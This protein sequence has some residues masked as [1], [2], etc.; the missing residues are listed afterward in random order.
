MHKKDIQEGGY[1]IAIKNRLISLSVLFWILFALIY[2]LSL[3]DI[4]SIGDFIILDGEY[5]ISEQMSKYFVFLG[6]LISINLYSVSDRLDDIR[7]SIC[8]MVFCLVMYLAE[9]NM[10]TNTL[11]PLFG[12]ILLPYIFTILARNRSWIPFLSLVLACNLIMVGVLIDFVLD[13]QAGRAPD[14]ITTLLP[15]SVVDIASS[16]E[17]ETFE[18][19]GAAFICYSVAVYSINP[20]QRVFRKGKYVILGFL[21]ASAMIA[22]GNSFLHW[23]VAIGR[24]QTFAA[25]SLC[26]M[27]GVLL[28]VVIN[29]VNRPRIIVGMPSQRE[30]LTFIAYFFVVLPSIFGR[31]NDTLSLV[32]WFPLVVYIGML[33]FVNHPATDPGKCKYLYSILGK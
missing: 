18:P 21:I 25:V 24:V 20:L 8:F 31:V 33:L 9:S 4:E 11:Q 2:I 19:V 16:M 10:I 12:V 6:V 32:L 29:R 23:M 30:V 15:S 22:I 17:E 27:G 5:E 26:I 13:S 14:L 3:M 7:L 28:S 1:G